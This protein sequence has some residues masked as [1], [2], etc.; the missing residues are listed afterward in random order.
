MQWLPERY[1]SSKFSMLNSSFVILKPSR[2]KKIMFQLLSYNIIVLVYWV[3][4]S[5]IILYMK[6]F[7]IF[8]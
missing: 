5:N 6:F 8:L 2:Q 4:D 1:S 7:Q 3:I